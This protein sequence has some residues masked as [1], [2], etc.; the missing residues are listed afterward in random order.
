MIDF[1][2]QLRRV[3]Q[4]DLRLR[5]HVQNVP[6]RH[7]L[8]EN[9]TVCHIIARQTDLIKREPEKSSRQPLKPLCEIR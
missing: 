1:S 4:Q 3:T 5:T 6:T 9:Q 8:T 2:R 7:V